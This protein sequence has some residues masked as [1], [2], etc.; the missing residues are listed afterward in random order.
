MSGIRKEANVP[1][2]LVLAVQP[3]VTVGSILTFRLS[4]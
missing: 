3:T 1:S 4:D 2:W